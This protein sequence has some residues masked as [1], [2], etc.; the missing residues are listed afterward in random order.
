LGRRIERALD[1]ARLERLD[2]RIVQTLTFTA[3]FLIVVGLSGARFTSRSAL[4][5]PLDETPPAPAATSDLREF[6]DQVDAQRARVIQERQESM[7][8]LA[9][10]G[11]VDN[12]PTN[13][14][15]PIF[16]SGYD[17]G[18][19]YNA[20]EEQKVQVDKIRARVEEIGRLKPEEL[21]A[22]RGVLGVD[23]PTITKLVSLLQDAGIEE[24]RSRLGGA[25][26][27]DLH[28]AEISALKKEYQEALQQAAEGIRRAQI[29]GL[30]VAERTLEVLQKRLQE[31][32]KQNADD[33]KRARGYADA[34]TRYLEDKRILEHLQM[35]LD[36]EKKKHSGPEPAS[37]S[38]K[39]P[40]NADPA[41]LD[42]ASGN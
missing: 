35:Q 11:I 10:S 37:Q 34:K 6:S 5:A 15:A 19:L 29:V 21:I 9:A 7:Q 12:D 3:A 20:V 14:S 1:P 24:K 39:K 30:G 27:S 33:K 18:T 23:D 17:S 38:N 36:S 41:A 22:A 26:A 8:L 2:G 13:A 31:S 42:P 25:G 4:A 32:E 40:S 16:A 28:L